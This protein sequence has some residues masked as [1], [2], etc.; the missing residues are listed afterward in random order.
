LRK[1]VLYILT[2]LISLPLAAEQKNVKQ[3]TG[4]S[5]FELQRA[6]GEISASLGVTCDS[7][8]MH[9]E[10][11]WDFASDEKKEKLR[12]REMIAMTRGVN[13]GTFGGRSTIACYTCHRGK[14]SPVGLVPL[15][16]APPAEEERRAEAAPPPNPSAEE[17][18]KKYAAAVGDTSRWASVRL[19]GTRESVDGKQ[20]NP[21]ELEASR[22]KYHVVAQTERGK[23]EQ[24]AG[25]TEGWMKGGAE[26]RAMS[27]SELARFHDQAASYE[28]LLPSDIPKE[29]RVVRKEKIGDHEVYAVFTIIGPK[30]RQRLYFD[31]RTGL[32]V[33]R[34]VLTD[35]PVGTI[36]QQTDFDDW[37]DAGGTKYPFI[38]KSYDP[39]NS[40]VR[41]YSE[42]TLG[43]KI[44]EKVFEK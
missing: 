2:L 15:P 36:P 43:A 35:S 18:A 44:D 14:E 33:R 34:V 17:I 20:T 38:V 4:L 13:E 8:H 7:C 16:V 1:P 26:P 40:S 22:G 11:D 30:Q 23:M 21:I 28:P 6:M 3:L 37:R 25:A 24:S 5:D 41:K 19:K 32:L 39:R 42:V 12:A 27:A 10:H 29:A 9:K 31:T